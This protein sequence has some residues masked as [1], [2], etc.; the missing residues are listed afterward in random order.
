MDETAR[1]YPNS[2]S[3]LDARVLDIS[4][5]GFKAACTARVMLGGPVSVEI[6]G[7]GRLNGHVTWRRGDE[8]GASFDT[9][10]DMAQLPWQPVGGQAELSRLLVQRAEANHAGQVGQ[11][12]E[13]KRK[14]LA[15]LP[16]M[17]IA[18]AEP[19]RRRSRA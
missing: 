7:V 14:I 12:L 18:G 2:W 1:L 17:A 4:S 16:V 19:V 3:S 15:R 9:P 13:L 11:E 10:V 6:P 8:F 5:H